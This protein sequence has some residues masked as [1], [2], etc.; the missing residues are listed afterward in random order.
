[1]CA[2]LQQLQH[3][4]VGKLRGGHGCCFGVFP[5]AFQI[6]AF[7]NL[8]SA[9][10]A[11]NDSVCFWILISGGCDFDAAR[12]VAVIDRNRADGHPYDTAESAEVALNF[13]NVIAIIDLHICAYSD[14]TAAMHTVA[15]M[16]L[17][18]VI[19]AGDRQIGS[20]TDDTAARTR[21]ANIY[22]TQVSAVFDG[23]ADSIANDTAASCAAISSAY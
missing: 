6:V 14:D 16:N 18:G 11:A 4:A 15:F 5:C 13:P 8:N 23:A 21:S 19:A 1:M 12:I 9:F 3:R 17:T 2:S 7:F 20:R 22:R 10:A